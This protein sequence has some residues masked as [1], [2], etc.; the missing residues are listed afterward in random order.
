MVEAVLSLKTCTVDESCDV[1]AE[2]LVFAASIEFI[3]M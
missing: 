1:N 3:D 2:A